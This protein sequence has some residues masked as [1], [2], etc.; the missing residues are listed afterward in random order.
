MARL[1]TSEVT[2]LKL[3]P[4]KPSISSKCLGLMESTRKKKKKG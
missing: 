1:Q 2:P 4:Q 3:A